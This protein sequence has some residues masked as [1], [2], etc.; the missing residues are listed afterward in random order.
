MIPSD[1]RAVDVRAGQD[2]D[3]DP[4]ILVEAQYDLSERPIDPRVTAKLTTTLRDRLPARRLAS[5]NKPRRA[6]LRR[7]ISSA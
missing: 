2:H 7:A 1:L 3:G 6:D 5:P 4:V